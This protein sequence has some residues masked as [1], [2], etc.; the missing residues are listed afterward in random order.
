MVCPPDTP[1]DALGRIH[2]NSLNILRDTMSFL[3]STATATATATAV[4]PDDKGKNSTNINP[5]RDGSA[6]KHEQLMVRVFAA[7]E[8]ESSMCKAMC[9]VTVIQLTMGDVV[10]AEQ[11]FLQE[12][13]NNKQ[14]LN[15]QECRLAETFINAIKNH[16]LDKVSES[17]GT[18]VFTFISYT[19]SSTALRKES[20]SYSSII[21]LTRHRHRVRVFMQLDEALLCNDLNY[22]DKEIITLAKRLSVFGSSSGSAS[23]SASAPSALPSSSSSSTRSPA[24]KALFAKSSG[25]GAGAGTGK[26]T[27]SDRDASKPKSSHSKDSKDRDVNVDMNVD[28]EVI[29]NGVARLGLGLPSHDTEWSPELMDSSTGTGRGTG[30]AHH[31]HSHSHSDGGEDDDELDLT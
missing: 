16:D 23:A 18:I 22:L 29:A 31:S 13:L 25:T 30:A 4:D 11:T 9:A 28:T 7:F 24:A 17:A 6:L 21:A 14:Y 10:Q 12:H 8:M 26:G 3:L 1:D 20:Y 5:I 2:P 19:E 15:S 27:S